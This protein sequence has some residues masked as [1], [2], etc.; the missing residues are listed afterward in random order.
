MTRLRTALLLIGAL[1]LTLLPAVPA[2]ALLPAEA[3]QAAAASGSIS[4]TIT[5]DRPDFDPTLIAVDA[6]QICDGCSGH[7]LVYPDTTGR[8]TVSDLEPGSY[9]VSFVDQPSLYTPGPY[10]SQYWRG[11]ADPAAA[12]PVVVR[13]GAETSGIDAR[14]KRG[15]SLSGRVT[16]ARTGEPVADVGVN[17]YRVGGPLDEFGDSQRN[18]YLVTNEN[19]EYLVGGIEPGVW[20]LHFDAS[21]T[22][23]D[24]APQWLG[25]VATVAQARRVTAVE[26]IDVGGLDVVLTPGA[27]VSGRVTGGPDAEPVPGVDVRVERP[28]E[29]IG[30]HSECDGG[31][32]QTDADGRYSVTALAAAGGYSVTAHPR[33]T[34]LAN[35]SWIGARDEADA[36]VFAV[37]EGGVEVANIVL[38]DAEPKPLFRDVP[39]GS[40]FF[41][42][43]Q[44][45]GKTK[46]S[47]GYADV[48]GTRA[49]RPVEAVS[50]QAMAAFLYRLHL[51]RGGDEFAPPV[52]A[53]FSDV[54]VTHPFFR[55]IEWMK[56]AGITTGDADGGYRPGAAVS[57]Q[58]M[59]AFLSRMSGEEVPAVTARP[60][61]DVPSTDAFA[62][63]IAWMARERIAS[64]Y[65]DGGFHPLDPVTRQAMAAFL[66]RYDATR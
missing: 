51:L 2:Q 43:V 12:T 32:A 41:D 30:G 63:A 33:I 65:Q 37:A 31:S 39:E 57:R 1:L 26:G 23:A 66:F 62:A 46:I 52:R 27:T 54:P 38:P 7:G 47:T 24:L 64:G 25:A 14:M 18:A 13:A 17:A 61:P 4:G 6:V 59:S 9:Q 36:T 50:R 45:L 40:A 22:S 21:D 16:S 8:Y 35:G 3:A 11:T 34:G 42:E 58:A 56:A 60:F 49:Y 28:C 48:G 15:P 5:G 29:S 19:G 20:V 10:R 44:W 55:E 53:S